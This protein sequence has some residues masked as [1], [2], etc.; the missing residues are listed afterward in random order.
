MIKVIFQGTPV[1]REHLG[2]TSMRK[3][4]FE[5]VNLKKNMKFKS[6]KSGNK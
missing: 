2:G 6:G 1:S 3:N 4:I 5:E